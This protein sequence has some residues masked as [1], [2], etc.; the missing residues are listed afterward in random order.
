MADC[1]F[2][3]LIKAGKN[4]VYEDELVFAMHAPKPAALGHVLVLPKKHYMII[5]QIPDYEVAD[6][7]ERV[8][9]L[10][11]AVFEAVGAHGTNIILQN[12]VAAG[13][14]SSHL[15]I[16]IIP[17]RENDGLPFAWQPIH[18]SEEEMSTIELKIK[19]AAKN[20]G[21]FE[22]KKP[23]PVEIDKKPEEIKQDKA[24]GPNYLIKHLRRIP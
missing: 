15:I 21:A 18:L 8:N 3:S 14:N 13:Q 10:S 11:V 1:E 23:K 22:K 7:F 6:I 9:K 19:D 5:E 24:S 12:G 20:I 17:R 16:H 2:C 4:M